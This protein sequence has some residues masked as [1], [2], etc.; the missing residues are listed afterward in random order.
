MSMIQRIQRCHLST[1]QRLGQMS[2]TQQV[3]PRNTR[4]SLSEAH[5][6]FPS[7]R[8]GSPMMKQS[9]PE[10]DHS[11]WQ[12][13]LHIQTR[14]RAHRSRCPKALKRSSTSILTRHEPQRS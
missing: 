6:T 7:H 13:E 14:H 11:L 5:R 1:F 3:H 2:T 8:D 9:P 4:P 10:V 12:M